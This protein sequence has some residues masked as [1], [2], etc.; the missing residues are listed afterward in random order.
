MDPDQAATDAE[1]DKADLLA[2]LGKLRDT[3]GDEVADS[4]MGFRDGAGY[5]RMR[6]IRLFKI[7]M[8]H[9]QVGDNKT[10]VDL[11]CESIFLDD[12]A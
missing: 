7:A 5:E 8:E 11:I 12:W 6:T 3:L 9:L 2:E 1:D 10:L 4:A